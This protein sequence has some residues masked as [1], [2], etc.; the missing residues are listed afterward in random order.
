MK[1]ILDYQDLHMFASMITTFVWNIL[2]FCLGPRNM[3]LVLEK[4]LFHVK[5]C[6]YLLDYILP[7]KH[8]M[9][10]IP[11]AFR[12]T[13]KSNLVLPPPQHLEL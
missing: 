13:K 11:F 10:F 3:K 5:I 8:A 6:K 4:T 9:I 12:M 1:V 7:S 2:M